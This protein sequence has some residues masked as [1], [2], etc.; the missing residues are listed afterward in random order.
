MFLKLQILLFSFIFNN[1][2]TKITATLSSFFSFFFARFVV[3]LKYFEKR[4]LCI[5][6]FRARVVCFWFLTVFW[7]KEK[8]CS[9]IIFWFIIKL[10]LME[11]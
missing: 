5:R 6:V 3:E 7:F 4:Y 1:F 9:L 8:N 11:K 10:G 2:I